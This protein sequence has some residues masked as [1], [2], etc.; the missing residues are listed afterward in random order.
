ML[1]ISHAE[2]LFSMG[3]LGKAKTQIEEVLRISPKNY[4]ATMLFSRILS[5]LSEYYLAEETLRDL[6]ITK[7]T[8]PLIWLQLSE[9]QRAGKNIL[10]YHMSLGEYHLILG[11][12]DES[13]NQFRF[14]LKLSEEN[15]QTMEYILEKIKLIQNYQRERSR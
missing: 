8:N 14:A 15:F 1:Q 4:P 13:M 5:G 10:G 7:K 2:I 6:L 3:E 9:I 11:Q 12:I